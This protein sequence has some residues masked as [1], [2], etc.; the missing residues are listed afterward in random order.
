MKELHKIKYGVGMKTSQAERDAADHSFR[1]GN[2]S[3]PGDE[4]V[5]DG[6]IAFIYGESPTR[7][8]RPRFV[9]KRKIRVDISRLS[10]KFMGG[11][12]IGAR[13]RGNV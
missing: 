6:R 13:Q 4:S 7:D 9:S 2:G 1:P 11:D 8:Y 12:C 10:V 5:D 3:S